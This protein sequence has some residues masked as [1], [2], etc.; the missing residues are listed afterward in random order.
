MELLD[1]SIPMRLSLFSSA[2]L[3]LTARCNYRCPFCYCI[4]HEQ[5]EQPAEINSAEWK[6]IIDALAGAE[7]WQITFTGGEPL[8]KEGLEEILEYAAGCNRFKTISIYTNASRLSVPFLKQLKNWNIN[9]N[10]SLQGLRTYGQSTGT[11]RTF[12]RGNRQGTR[13]E[14][15]CGLDRDFNQPI[16]IYRH[17]GRLGLDRSG[18]HHLRTIHGGGTRP[19]PPGIGAFCTGME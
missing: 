16:G 2:A 10:V 7:V 6:R 1:S 11:R 4:W 18:F 5:E 9:L 13:F 12:P 8:L 14:S 15:S 17:G 19:D 3:E